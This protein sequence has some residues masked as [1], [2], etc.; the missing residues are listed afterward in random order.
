VRPI[1]QRRGMI[2][3]GAARQFHIVA[4]I[5]E[6]ILH[7]D[8]DT[9]TERIEAVYGARAHQLHPID[10]N[11]RKQIPI[12]SVAERLVDAHA[13]LIDRQSLRRTQHG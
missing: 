6:A 2:T 5:T 8:G 11:I 7:A 9:P 1:L 3:E 4:V 12:D 10:R 13:I